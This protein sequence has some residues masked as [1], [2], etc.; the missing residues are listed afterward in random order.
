MCSK[1][2][3]DGVALANAHRPCRIT[4]VPN[5]VNAGDFADAVKVKVFQR[6]PV[7]IITARFPSQI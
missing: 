5:N 2:I 6:T 1:A 3:F 4:L 7:T